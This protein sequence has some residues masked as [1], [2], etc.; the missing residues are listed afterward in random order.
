MTERP[1]NTLPDKQQHHV[2]TPDKHV[3]IEHPKKKEDAVEE[4]KEEVKKEKKVIV[5]KEEAVVNG[6]SVNASLKH[7]MYIGKFVKRKKIDSALHDLQ[8]VIGF[9]KIVPF[10]GEIP[11]RHGPGMMSGRYPQVAS[12]EFI[13]LLKQLKGNCIANGM[14]LERVRI[15]SVCPSWAARP[16]RR[17][18]RKGKRVNIVII[19]KEISEKENKKNG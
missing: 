6:Y 1:T 9:R 5:K 8:E 11:H 10:K 4:K 12:V 7:C 16:M 13:R 18:G 14:D 15:Y 2:A 3:H 17:G 19:A